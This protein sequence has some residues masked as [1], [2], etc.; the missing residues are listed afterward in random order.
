MPKFDFYFDFIGFVL[1]LVFLVTVIALPFAFGV[2]RCQIVKQ[3]RGMAFVLGGPLVYWA[4]EHRGYHFDR[5]GFIVPDRD[6]ENGVVTHGP[7]SWVTTS[8][9]ESRVVPWL[10]WRPCF[11]LVLHVGWIVKPAKYAD[12]NSVGDGFGDGEFFVILHEQL[13]S[14]TLTNVQTK[15]GNGAETVTADEITVTFKMRV[16]NPDR[17]L[18]MTPADVVAQVS[19]TMKTIMRPAIRNR[20]PDEVLNLE[21]N[22]RKLWNEIAAPGSC[23]RQTIVNLRN[24]W[25][26]GI[27]PYSISIEGAVFPQ[28]VQDAMGADQREKLLAKAQARRL[29]GRVLELAA[30]RHGLAGGAGEAQTLLDSTP[31]GKKFLD[32]MLLA[33]S[34]IP[35]QTELGSAYKKIDLTGLGGE[36]D[37]LLARLV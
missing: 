34:Q 11:G 27:V 4:I 22:S 24:D 7:N 6:P 8:A 9:K 35:L 32:E 21:A 18:T 28:A 30:V 37:K 1:D 17:F 14:I 19:K 29:M 31:E 16:S 2:I 3:A 15:A 10:I 26:V 36:I 5:D 12:F 23:S 13:K 33:C 25:G 20:T